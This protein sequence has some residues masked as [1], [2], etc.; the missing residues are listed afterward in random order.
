LARRPEPSVPVFCLNY[1]PLL[2]RAA[3]HRK[4]R[5]MDGFLGVEQAYF[6]AALFQEQIG[7][8][9]RGRR[10]PQVR[11]VTGNI[12]LFK[13]HGSLGWYDCPMEGVRR[14][15]FTLQI[16][17]ETKRLMVPPQHRKATDTT[18]PPY[19]ALWSEFRRLV[20]HGPALLNRLAC[21][22]YGMRDE[23]VNAVLEN[24]LARNDFTLMIFAKTL[25][26][27]TFDRWSPRR[28]VVVVTED[29][30]SLSGEAG[31]GH[32]DLWSFERLSCEV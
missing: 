21:I 8:I 15:G 32:S 2:E 14:C 12:H 17:T 16:P 19:A 3:E 9:Q 7:T 28:N 20:R 22:G 5:L 1:D 18:A 6:D 25:V 26:A 27:D 10:H 4:L 23:H 11:W 29:R 31:P 13:L 24:G 30:C